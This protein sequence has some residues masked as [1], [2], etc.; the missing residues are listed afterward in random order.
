MKPWLTL[1][2]YL[3]NSRATALRYSLEDSQ[4][5]SDLLDGRTIAFY[6]RSGEATF[7]ANSVKSDGLEIAE[8]ANRNIAR[9]H[10]EEREV[11]LTCRGDKPS[12]HLETRS[13][14]AHIGGKGR[15]SDR[16]DIALGSLNE[17]LR[18]GYTILF[19]VNSTSSAGPYDQN[20][21]L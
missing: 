19:L 18:R 20:D 16:S 1:L 14:R 8:K 9:P 21:C 17:V 7:I 2:V 4:S 10:C 3:T 11:E 5:R 13:L 12:L 6:A 15:R